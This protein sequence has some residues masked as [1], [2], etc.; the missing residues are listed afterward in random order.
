MLARVVFPEDDQT[1]A[2]AEVHAK[3]V[4]NE[5]RVLVHRV[6]PVRHRVVEHHFVL[7]VLRVAELGCLADDGRV[8][9]LCY[10]LNLLKRGLLVLGLAVVHD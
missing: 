5:Q 7:G 4:P 8:V 10:L 3:R 9:L 1:V 6:A 2:Q